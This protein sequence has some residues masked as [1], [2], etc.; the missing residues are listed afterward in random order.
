MKPTAKII[1]A[2]KEQV[3]GLWLLVDSGEGNQAHPIT[4]EEVEPIRDACNKWLLDNTMDM[5]D[6]LDVI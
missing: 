4:P 2:G 5:K 6:F 3:K 1:E